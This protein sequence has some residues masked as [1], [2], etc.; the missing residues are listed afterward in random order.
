MKKLVFVIRIVL[1]GLITV[2]CKQ[3]SGRSKP[4][5]PLAKSNSS[6][7]PLYTLNGLHLTDA[8][9]IINQFL[10]NRGSYDNSKQTSIWFSQ[11]VFHAMYS[12]ISK[13]ADGIRIYFAKTIPDG[14]YTFVVVSTFAGGPD[15]SNTNKNMHIDYF[16]H[17]KLTTSSGNVN[18]DVN[19]DTAGGGALLYAS[20]TPPCGTGSDGCDTTKPHYIPCKKAFKMVNYFGTDSINATSEWF[21]LGIIKDLD[22]VLVAQKG[23]G[24]RIYFSRHLEPDHSQMPDTI[25]RHGFVIITT[26]LSADAS[27]NQINLD[28]YDCFLTHPIYKDK[29]HHP[30]YGGTDN[31]E[32]CPTNCSG[33]T[34]P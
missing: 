14:K 28:N 18:G 1:L 17:T 31:G 19:Y 34:W 3:N 16:Q 21:D 15:P 29:M 11:P 25:H 24:I 22:S 23:N 20:K 5:S 13:Q 9:A 30:F 10:Q 12:L 26:K 6:T 32:Q 33:T 27:G 2:S 4:E 7:L 8:D